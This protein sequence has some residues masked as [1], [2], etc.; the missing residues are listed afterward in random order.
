MYLY[1]CNVRVNNNDI[2]SINECN[3]YIC[4]VIDV[5]RSLILLIYICNYNI[6]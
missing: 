4:L 3:E 1:L 6:I 5:V 2:N